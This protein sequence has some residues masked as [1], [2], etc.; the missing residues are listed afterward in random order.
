MHTILHIGLNEVLNDISMTGIIPNIVL[1]Y[2]IVHIHIDL[3][4]V[5]YDM[6]MTPG[7]ILNIVLQY[8]IVHL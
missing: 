8:A 7:I 2:A 4:E 5:L 1:Q 6:L 3:N